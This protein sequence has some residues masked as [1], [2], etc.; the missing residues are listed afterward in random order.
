MARRTGKPSEPLVVR[1]GRKARDRR[2]ELGMNQAEVAQLAHITVGKVS[3]FENARS[4]N[5]GPT[6]SMIERVAKA[7]RVEPS[8]LLQAP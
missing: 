8:E 7:L 6:L 3:E 1:V 2:V 4:G 5:R